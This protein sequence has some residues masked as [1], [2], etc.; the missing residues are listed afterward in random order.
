MEPRVAAR[1]LYD[2]L[3]R[4]PSLVSVGVSQEAGLVC[5]IVYT[6]TKPLKAGFTPPSRWEGYPVFVRQL[7]Q[8]R[9][10]TQRSFSLG[11]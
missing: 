10:V 1:A 3:N 11:L 5:L 7:G 4:H 2:I 6:S 8:V 9:P